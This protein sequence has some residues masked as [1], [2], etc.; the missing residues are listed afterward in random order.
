VRERVSRPPRT[1]PDRTDSTTPR[2]CRST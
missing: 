2:G 1:N